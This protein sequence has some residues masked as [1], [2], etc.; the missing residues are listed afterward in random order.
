[1]FLESN[2]CA[3]SLVGEALTSGLLA[4]LEAAPGLVSEALARSFPPAAR[5]IRVA[6]LN[7]GAF[8]GLPDAVE[9]NIG[10]LLAGWAFGSGALL[11]NAEAEGLVPAELRTA[12]EYLVSWRGRWRWRGLWRWL[13]L[14]RWLGRGRDSSCAGNAVAFFLAPHLSFFGAFVPL[15]APVVAHAVVRLG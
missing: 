15:G 6:A 5:F 9:L 1:V 11:L 12:V 3:F 7:R 4:L 8:R 2:A 13:W 10:P 14:W